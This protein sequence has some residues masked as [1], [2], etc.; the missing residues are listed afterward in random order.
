MRDS[1]EC[2]NRLRELAQESSVDPRQAATK[3]VQQFVRGADANDLA[4]LR[5]RLEDT[6]DAGKYTEVPVSYLDQHGRWLTVLEGAC[7]A[8]KR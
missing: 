6:L 1:Q 4:Q 3:I 8:V 7:V 2:W 5:H